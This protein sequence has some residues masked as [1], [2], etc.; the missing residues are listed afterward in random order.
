MKHVGGSRAVA[1]TAGIKPTSIKTERT[2][3]KPKASGSDRSKQTPLAASTS[4]PRPN[5][6][7]S[8]APSGRHAH[9][10]GAEEGLAIS[11]ERMHAQRL[12]EPL[13][14]P[15]AV[16]EHLVAVQAQDVAGAKWALAQRSGASEAEI[17]RAF[18]AGEILRTHVLRPTWHFA[19][20]ADLPWL[21]ALTSSV[22]QRKCAAYY[23]Q[24]G[25]TAAKLARFATVIAKTLDGTSA[26]RA[27][28]GR[29]L[30]L[31]ETGQTLGHVML[32]AELERVVVSGPRRG[33]QQ[34][35]ARFEDRV[36]ASAVPMPGETPASRDP[37]LAALAGRYVASHGPAR[38]IDFAWWSG[39]ALAEARRAIELAIEG[40]GISRREREGVEYV[41]GTERVAIPKVSIVR[42]LPNYDE[43]LVAFADRAAAHD[44]RVAQLD[45]AA[46]FANVV[47]SNGRVIG[48]WRRE[49]GKAMV[50][51]CTL[52]IEPTAVERAGIDAEVARLGSFAGMP[53]RLEVRIDPKARF[54][55]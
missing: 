11:L 19:T 26:T 23:K 46:I 5:P 43:M 42:L 55:G 24:N 51:T 30:G 52:A 7:R 33:K 21:M 44:P 2:K 34:T 35:Y 14:T 37:A 36:V 15:V 8:A 22:I 3:P 49:H 39:L 50:L 53:V 54:R 25:L 12:V 17:D 29:A 28:L 40:G 6:A 41:E 47:T 1:K 32:H 45:P 10:I 20:R 48:A 18:D 38:V 4:K 9:S 31:D 16:V 27:E 13:A